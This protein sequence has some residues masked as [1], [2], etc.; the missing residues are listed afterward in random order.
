MDGEGITG[1]E[2]GV[3][4]RKRCGYVDRRGGGHGGVGRFDAEEGGMLFRKRRSHPVAAA[5]GHSITAR[6]CNK[7]RAKL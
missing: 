3:G 1:K 5:L 4:E 2:Q 7:N 6:N